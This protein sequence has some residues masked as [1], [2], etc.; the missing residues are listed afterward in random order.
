MALDFAIQDNCILDMRM[1][2]MQ[3]IVKAGGNQLPAASAHISPAVIK[4]CF[5][6][7]AISAFIVDSGRHHHCDL[8]FD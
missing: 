5:T 4:R 6:S 7:Y 2:H 8:S 1:R 3:C